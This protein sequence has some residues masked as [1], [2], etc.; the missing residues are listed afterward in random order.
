MRLRLPAMSAPHRILVAVAVYALLTSCASDTTGPEPSASISEPSP[1]SDTPSVA[2]TLRL[3]DPATPTAAVK[4][5]VLEYRPRFDRSAGNRHAAV[6]VRMC[7]TG[8][9]V[10]QPFDFSSNS[11]RLRTP[12]GHDYEAFQ[13]AAAPGVVQ[14]AL[15][16]E[17]PG[18]GKC[19]EGW[20]YY[21]VRAGTKTPEAVLVEGPGDLAVWELKEP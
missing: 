3:G 12:G 2:T 4:A 6:L 20:I 7:S 18:A 19:T 8:I 9:Q 11:W 14:P 15:D 10:G 13:P 17:Q 5:S 1:T 16:G 21:K